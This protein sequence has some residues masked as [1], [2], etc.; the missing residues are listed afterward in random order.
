MFL[1]TTTIDAIA[2]KREEGGAYIDD[3][4]LYEGKAQGDMYDGL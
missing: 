2:S 1:I 4:T 3:H